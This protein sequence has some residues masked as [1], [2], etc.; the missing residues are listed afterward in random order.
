[1]RNITPLTISTVDNLVASKMNWSLLDIP[2]GAYADNKDK[3]LFI[4][5]FD[6][7]DNVVYD[8]EANLPFASYV[9]FINAKNDNI[10]DNYISSL[11]NVTLL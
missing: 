7:N 9:S 4:E 2:R 3:R 10:I 8:K 11:L 5:L 1:M 6:A